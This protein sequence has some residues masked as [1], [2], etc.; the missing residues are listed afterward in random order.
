MGLRMVSMNEHDAHSYLLTKTG[1]SM[2]QYL[3]H[4]LDLFV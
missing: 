3:Y 1:V 2:S 4:T